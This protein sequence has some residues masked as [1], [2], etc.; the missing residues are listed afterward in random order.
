MPTNL[1]TSHPFQGTEPGCAYWHPSDPQPCGVVR[2]MHAPAAPPA[3]LSPL[4]AL[5]PAA[6]DFHRYGWNTPEHDNEV[7]SFQRPLLDLL[8]NIGVVLVQ[9]RDE[10]RRR[11]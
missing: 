6:Q 7:G 3:D 2:E 11:P 4:S 5:E 1:I 9:I 10:L 8:S